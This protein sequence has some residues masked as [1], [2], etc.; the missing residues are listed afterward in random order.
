MESC[1]FVCLFAC[2][3]FVCLFACLF[4]CL[5][6]FCLFVC[7][8]VCLSIGISII[9]AKTIKLTRQDQ[10]S[11]FSVYLYVCPSIGPPTWTSL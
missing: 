2:L 8:S 7:L 9:T 4:V 11:C 6:A 10:S 5:S 3:F 1:L